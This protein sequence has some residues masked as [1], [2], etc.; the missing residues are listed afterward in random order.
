MKYLHT[1]KGYTLLFSVLVATLVLSVAAFILSISR[2]QLILSAAARDSMYAF[3]ASDSGIECA[4][5][6]YGAGVFATSSIY[7]GSIGSVECN[8]SNWAASRDSSPSPTPNNA[9]TTFYMPLGVSGTTNAC[10]QIKVG[11]SQ[12]A[13]SN[14]TYYIESR[15]YNIG[16]NQTG[17]ASGVIFGDCTT[18]GPRKVERGLR[19]TYE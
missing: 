19:L 5:M 4:V 7:A 14:V 16:W 18:A 3:Y 17:N 1:E 6:N 11:Y 9:T 15:G 2:K 12:P 8:G 13:G 10:A